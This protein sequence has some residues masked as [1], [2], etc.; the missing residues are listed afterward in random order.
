MGMISD[1]NFA[2]IAKTA[3]VQEPAEV[4][5]ADLKDGV[6]LGTMENSTDKSVEAK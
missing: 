4:M 2:E 3:P 1:V 6:M 5:T